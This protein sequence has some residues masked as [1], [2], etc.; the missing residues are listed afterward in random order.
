MIYLGLP[1]MPAFLER[2]SV[3]GVSP[4][5]RQWWSFWPARQPQWHRFSGRLLD[6]R[7][8]SRLRLR[9][10]WAPSLNYW[11][12][13]FLPHPSRLEASPYCLPVCWPPP[14]PLSLVMPCCP[15][16]SNACLAPPLHP[17]SPSAPCRH[18]SLRPPPP[19]PRPFRPGPP[20]AAPLQ[21]HPTRPPCTAALAMLYS[22]PL[23][24]DQV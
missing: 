20:P 11:H 14:L 12:S 7:W 1:L 9:K 3:S 13:A 16:S 19:P 10:M 5:Q 4:P 15:H 2:S 23:L 6:R 22:C 21:P 8:V 18:S 24:L 17:T